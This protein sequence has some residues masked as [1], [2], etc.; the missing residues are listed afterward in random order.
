MTRKKRTHKQ[1][2][3]WRWQ[4]AYLLNRLP[5]Q[6]WADLVTWA[7]GWH[8]GEKRTPWSPMRMCRRDMAE[9]GTCYCGKI[10]AEDLQER[11]AAAADKA[12][13]EWAESEPK[14]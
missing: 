6:C 7:L 14:T 5:N 13:A 9:T 2:L 8:K 11:W 12:A 4:V 3:P 10:R 1:W